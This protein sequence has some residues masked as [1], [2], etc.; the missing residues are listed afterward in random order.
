VKAAGYSGISF[1][2]TDESR[3]VVTFDG[4]GDNRTEDIDGYHRLPEKT[5]TLGVIGTAGRK[6]RMTKEHFVFMVERTKKAIAAI[7]QATGAEAVRLVSG[8]AAWSDHVAV[9]LFMAGEVDAISLHLGAQLEGNAFT[10]KQANDAGDVMNKYHRQFS[11]AMTDG[12]DANWSLE[13]IQG[14]SYIYHQDPRDERIQ[15]TFQNGEIK[16][17]FDR[18][19]LIAK[20]SDFL[21]AFTFGEKGPIGGTKDTYDKYLAMGKKNARHVSLNS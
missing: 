17:L 9:S 15:F 13:D 21:I 20:D 14:L 4:D 8:G 3:Y 5:V 2:G 10:V 12:Q 6:E 19:T 18:N 11:L 1:L 16:G 7:K